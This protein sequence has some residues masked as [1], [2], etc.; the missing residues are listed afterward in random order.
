MTPDLLGWQ[1]HVSDD[2]HN[3]AA[4]SLGVTLYRRDTEGGEQIIG[5]D[6]QGWPII[7]RLLPLAVP[8][9]GFRIPREAVH[10]LAEAV[11]PGPSQGEVKRLEE[12]LAHEREQ[13]RRLMDRI[14]ELADRAPI[15]LDVTGRLSDQQVDEI[16]SAWRPRGRH[17]GGPP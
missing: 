2:A 10:A 12:A 5:F 4:D 6:D 16:Q 1:V 8:R 7:E 14:G 11:K 17:G 9:P 15:V 3:W 13:V